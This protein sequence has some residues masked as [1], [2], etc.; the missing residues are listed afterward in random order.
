VYHAWNC[1]DCDTVYK[2]IGLFSSHP[3]QRQNCMD[4]SKWQELY[5][6]RTNWSYRENE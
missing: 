3:V 1:V 5:T 6:T 4:K 2:L